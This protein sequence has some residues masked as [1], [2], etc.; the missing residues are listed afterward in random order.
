MLAAARQL[1][2]SNPLKTLMLSVIVLWCGYLFVVGGEQGDY[3][4]EC[5]NGFVSLPKYYGWR[6]SCGEVVQI[7]SILEF[8]S[9]MG[10]IIS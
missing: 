10:L 4:G 8:K 9:H 6:N 7:V 2:L 5:L 3:G 1:K